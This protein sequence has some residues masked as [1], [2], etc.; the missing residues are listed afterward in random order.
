MLFYMIKYTYLDTIFIFIELILILFVC[1][2]IPSEILS[3]IY[4]KQV[5]LGIYI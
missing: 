5:Q 3:I 2:E 4:I 1:I